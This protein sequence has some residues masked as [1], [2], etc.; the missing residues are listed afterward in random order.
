MG[1]W[2]WGGW[3]S[4]LKGFTYTDVRWDPHIPQWN[5][6]LV[7]SSE[8]VILLASNKFVVF[9]L[10]G[11]FHVILPFFCKLGVT[12]R[13]NHFFGR[14]F[15]IKTF[16]DVSCL[17]KLLRGQKVAD[18]FGNFCMYVQTFASRWSEGLLV[19]KLDHWSKISTPNKY[20]F[21]HILILTLYAAQRHRS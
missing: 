6:G 20:C 10:R 2:E 5:R 9:W 13:L 8:S 19:L 21:N 12:Q 7:S 1:T 15:Q 16:V 11:A 4:W 18:V 14:N 3:W 17:Q